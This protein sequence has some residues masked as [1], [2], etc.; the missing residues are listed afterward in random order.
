MNPCPSEFKRSRGLGLQHASVPASVMK[1]NQ[2]AAVLVGGQQPMRLLWNGPLGCSA[3]GDFNTV[4]DGV[5]TATGLEI[6]L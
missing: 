1:V 2:Q 5:F 3:L 6:L 4:R